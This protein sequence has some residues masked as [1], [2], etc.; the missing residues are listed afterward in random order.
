MAAVT[1]SLKATATPSSVVSREREAEAAPMSA[2]AL[3]SGVTARVALVLSALVLLTVLVAM[4][5]KL[6]PLSLS[7]TS[8]I[9]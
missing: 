3:V 1:F 2:G 5:A 8:L 6:A 9:V 4:T 7:N